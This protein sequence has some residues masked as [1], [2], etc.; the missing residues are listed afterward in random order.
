MP[1]IVADID[2][3]EFV[4]PRPDRKCGAVERALELNK[5]LIPFDNSRTDGKPDDAPSQVRKFEKIEQ[6]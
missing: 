6:M 4:C 2:E 3:L 5:F 1:A